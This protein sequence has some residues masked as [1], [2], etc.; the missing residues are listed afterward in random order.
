MIRGS[1]DHQAVVEIKVAGPHLWPGNPTFLGVVKF[2]DALAT[3]AGAIARFCRNTREQFFRDARSDAPARTFV[4]RCGAELAIIRPAAQRTTLRSVVGR[5]AARSMTG[6]CH[7][8]QSRLRRAT[9]SAP[10]PS[11]ASE[12]VVGSGTATS[13]SI[14]ALPPR[15]SMRTNPTL[16]SEI[17]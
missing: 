5:R 10:A 11:N 7:N 12:T 9:M 15:T 17:V 3:D 8:N 1:K 6:V 2:H 4:G 16:D 14:S 13:P